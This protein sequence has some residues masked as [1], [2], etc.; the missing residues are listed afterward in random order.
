FVKSASSRVDAATAHRLRHELRNPTARTG[1]P[2]SPTTRPPSHDMTPPAPLTGLAKTLRGT[3]P[4]MIQTDDEAHQLAA[5]W[6]YHRF[7]E[8]DMVAW[9]RHG[10]TPHDYATARQLE[11]YGIRPH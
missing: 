10:L 6:T 4:Q 7:T 8:E 11:S 5:Q 3:F 9:C 2:Q 1:T